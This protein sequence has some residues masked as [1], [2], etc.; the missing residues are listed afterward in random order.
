[1]NTYTESANSDYIELY[2]YKQKKG[3]GMTRFMSDHSLLLPD[4]TVPEN[5]INPVFSS[6]QII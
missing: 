6:I 2:G 4:I 1:M 3:R 5:F